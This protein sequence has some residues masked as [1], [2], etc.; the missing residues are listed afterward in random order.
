MATIV[1]PLSIFILC[2]RCVGLQ[3]PDHYKSLFCVQDW[4]G[5]NL[6]TIIN[7]YSVSRIGMA[8]IPRPLLIF[9]L[10]LGWVWLQSLDHYQSLFCVQD[11][12]VYNLLT[13]TILYS[14]SRMG[15]ATIAR[16]LSIF[17]LSLGWVW[18]QSPDHYQSLFYVQDGHGDNRQIIINL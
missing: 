1:R 15:V 8:T 13:N 17:I 14:V 5:Y 12:Y 7:L 11:V 18:L 4:Y 16:P 3:S 2:L 9:L 6:Q 10:F